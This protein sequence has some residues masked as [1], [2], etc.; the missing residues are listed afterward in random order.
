[1]RRM[2]TN[3]VPNPEGQISSWCISA[4][5][6]EEFVELWFADPCHVEE[7]FA[8]LCDV[9]GVEGSEIGLGLVCRAT[10]E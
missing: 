4:V 3:P 10:G 5:P 8:L 9:G 1:M 7:Q 2:F 6:L